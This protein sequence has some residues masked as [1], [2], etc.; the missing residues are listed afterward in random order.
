[1]NQKHDKNY[2]LKNVDKT[3]GGVHA[4]DNLKL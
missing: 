1:M 4:I 2:E 3:F